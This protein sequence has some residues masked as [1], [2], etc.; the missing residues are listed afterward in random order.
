MADEKKARRKW[1]DAD[2]LAEAAE[3][4]EKRR[5]ALAQAEADLADLKEAIK[6]KRDA[7]DEA[8]K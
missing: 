7:L 4:V 8:L 6:A 5:A 3:R 2:R 1:T